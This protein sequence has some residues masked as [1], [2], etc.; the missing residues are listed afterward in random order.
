MA[1]TKLFKSVL[2]MITLLGLIAVPAQATV[3]QYNGTL[4]V[5][6]GDGD[7]DIPGDLDFANN[8]IPPCEAISVTAMGGATTASVKFVGQASVIPGSAPQAVKFFAQTGPLGLLYTDCPFFPQ[9]EFGLTFT[10]RTQ[11]AT[12]TWPAA[13]GTVS[14]SGGFGG[15]TASPFQ[16]APAWAIAGQAV[17]VTAPAGGNKFGGA[18]AMAGNGNSI[19]G[20]NVGAATVFV[21]ELPVALSLGKSGTATPAFELTDAGTFFFQQSAPVPAGCNGKQ[22]CVTEGVTP[23]FDDPG[24]AL[25]TIPVLAQAAF[26]PWT[27]GKI[28]VFDDL[29]NFTTTRT[30]TGGDARNSLGTTGVLQLVTPTVLLITGLSPIGLAITAQLTLDFVPEPAAT[31]ML[32]SGGLVLLGLYSLH[33]RK[34]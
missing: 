21:G 13:S 26:F 3:V 23:G 25:A 5:G 20:L 17:Q 14:A 1:T 19:L 28:R 15:S 8:A 4:G 7:V 33:R 30:R 16:Y 12:I 2:G 9:T 31:A 29:G 27:T 6:F 11:M 10:R 22:T 32:A 18:V 24:P 34:R